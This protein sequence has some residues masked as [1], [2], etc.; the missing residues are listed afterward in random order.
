M[1]EITSITI[2]SPYVTLGQFLKLA[3]IIQS[4][5]F[6]KTYLSRTVI[7]INDAIDNRRGRKLY[8]G[9]RIRVEGR[10]YFIVAS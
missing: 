5:G 8:P 6:A 2:V 3:N 9:D 4:G 10:E 1:K 7:V